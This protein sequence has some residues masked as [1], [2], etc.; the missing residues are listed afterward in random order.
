AVRVFA[1][2]SGAV[3]AEARRARLAEFP[4]SLSEAEVAALTNFLS[5]AESRIPGVAPRDA[6]ALKNEAADVLVARAPD[7]SGLAA[8]FAARFLDSRNSRGWRDYALQALPGACLRDRSPAS[9]RLA[10]N[11][12]A[13]VFSSPRLRRFRGTAL[14]GLAALERAGVPAGG[15]SAESAALAV[16][17][18]PQ[19]DGNAVLTS[20]ALC[21]ERGWT[22][23]VPEL[24]RLAA[25]SPS[26]LVRRAAASA[27]RALAATNTDERL[28]AALPPENNCGE[29]GALVK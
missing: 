18:D 6:L 4:D 3:S 24:R 1:S 19:P 21:R 11:A 28:S 10:G 2:L 20:A 22:N 9:L 17:R 26:P 27:L 23:A 14:N 8:F 12:Y 5:V 25:S 15:I 13:A 29:S 7:G 16:L